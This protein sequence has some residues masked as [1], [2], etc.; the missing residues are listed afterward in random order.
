MAAVVRVPVAV[1]VATIDGI[2]FAVYASAAIPATLPTVSK[3]SDRVT[4]TVPAAPTLVFTASLLPTNSNALFFATV[5]DWPKV[6]VASAASRSATSAYPRSDRTS[7][8]ALI[9][10]SAAKSRNSPRVFPV[11]SAMASMM[12]GAFSATE[13]NSSPRNAPAA[14]PCPSCRIAPSI[15][16]ADAPETANVWLMVLV[17]PSSSVCDSPRSFVDR[18]SETY[19]SEVDENPARVSFATAISAFCVAAK[20][21]DDV[22]T[23]FILF[24]AFCHSSAY[25]TTCE[26]T[27]E[28]ASAVIAV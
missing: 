27:I 6:R 8:S 1:T 3:F 10:P 24:S 14:R 17:M 15:S 23:S 22:V 20:S 11:A 12:P 9:P 26:T 5:S 28:P 7:S 21:L 2:N 19:R 4:N 16:D 25:A 13:L 18:E